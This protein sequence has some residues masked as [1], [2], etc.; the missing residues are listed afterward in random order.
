MWEDWSQAWE[1]FSG[2]TRSVPWP[3]LHSLAQGSGLAGTLS[4]WHYR[5]SLYAAAD[6]SVAAIWTHTSYPDARLWNNRVAALAGTARST[7]TLGIA[8]ALAVSEAKIYGG[9]HNLRAA[10]F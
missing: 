2:R 3:G 6:E 10:N 4:V 9:A 8:A 1:H 7:G 5:S